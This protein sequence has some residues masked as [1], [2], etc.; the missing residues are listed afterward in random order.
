LPTTDYLKNLTSSTPLDQLTQHYNDVLTSPEF[1]QLSPQ[2][3]IKVRQNLAKNLHYN[4]EFESLGNDV[5]SPSFAQKAGLV[6]WT[7]GTRPEQHQVGEVATIPTPSASL[8]NALKSGVNQWL[9]AL[10]YQALY[11][12]APLQAEETAP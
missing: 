7:L 9:P 2:E 11:Q 8:L 5:S 3:Q 6:N 12:Q 4:P 1:T 10:G